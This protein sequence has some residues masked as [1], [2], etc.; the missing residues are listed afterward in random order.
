M[1]LYIEKSSLGSLLL[2][3]LA[4]FERSVFAQPNIAQEFSSSKRAVSI[5]IDAIF[6]FDS[7]LSRL[8]DSL[9]IGCTFHET[10]IWKVEIQYVDTTGDI[11][12]IRFTIEPSFLSGI[13]D[14][15]GVAMLLTG[16]S[17]SV[18]NYRV[19]PDHESGYYIQSC[20]LRCAVW[21]GTCPYPMIFSSLEDAL[22]LY[23]VSGVYVLFADI[24][25]EFKTRRCV[26]EGTDVV[27]FFRVPDLVQYFEVDWCI[28]Q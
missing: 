20:S 13:N 9:I 28:R 25:R 1:R 12:C 8:V 26:L 2:L 6:V 14:S 21:E 10:W 3:V 17:E 5:A 22:L 15:Q 11:I 16:S 4:M 7:T 27:N 19:I 23:K 24:N 18:R